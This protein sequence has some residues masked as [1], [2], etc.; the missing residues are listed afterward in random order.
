MC[1]MPDKW[2]TT[3][4]C[5]NL[6]PKALWGVMCDWKWNRLKDANPWNT[7]LI[8]ASDSQCT[9]ITD[10]KTLRGDVRTGGSRE[11]DR[12]RNH[13]GRSYLCFILLSLPLIPLPMQKPQYRLIHDR[14]YITQPRMLL[15]AQ[16]QKE[17]GIHTVPQSPLMG[18]LTLSALLT[19]NT[20]P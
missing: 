4:P 14:L 9:A 19:L 3:F 8:Q 16:S 7:T 13:L 11:G 6:Q 15:L 10:T 1:N 5:S 12:D 18:F 17:D 2:A 20:L